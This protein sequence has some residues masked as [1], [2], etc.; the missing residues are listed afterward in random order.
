MTMRTHLPGIGALAALALAMPSASGAYE[1]GKTPP[2][3]S[4]V[5]SGAQACRDTQMLPNA[6]NLAR[7]RG[8]VLCLINAER[9]K[10]GAKP[11]RVRAHLRAVAIRR[12][13]DM[14]RRH[15]FNHVTPPG[16][17]L[18]PDFL[19]LGL[20]GPA[21][22]GENIA[23]GSDGYSTALSIVA[24]WMSSTRH[25]RTM[26]SSGYRFTG[27]GL[28]VG[29]PRSLNPGEVAATYTQEFSTR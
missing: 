16:G 17:G 8:A 15:Y 6:A 23:W 5:A 28:A 9:A 19:H 26:L 4:A 18:N 27:I 13:R 11:L 24:G 25:R 21:V 10:R 1:R 7:I 22:T 14:V 20:R 3:T 12:S 29:A 2:A